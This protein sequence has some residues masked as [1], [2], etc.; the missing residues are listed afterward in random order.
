MTRIRLDSPSFQVATAAAPVRTTAIVG[1]TVAPE[2]GGT[3]PLVDSFE[4]GRGASASSPRLT[5]AEWRAQ[6]EAQRSAREDDGAWV[7]GLMFGAPLIGTKVGGESPPS[8][9]RIRPLKV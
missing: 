1:D 8:P 2:P 3:A 7:L 6:W 9:S 4:R 5:G